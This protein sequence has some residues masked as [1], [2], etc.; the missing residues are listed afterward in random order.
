LGSI[1]FPISRLQLFKL[2][3]T[4]DDHHPQL[5]K[6]FDL[7]SRGLFETAGLRP[8]MVSDQSPGG[9]TLTLIKKKLISQM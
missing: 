2:H 3:I 6:V 5:G 7:L 1:V 9:A 8:A 4:G